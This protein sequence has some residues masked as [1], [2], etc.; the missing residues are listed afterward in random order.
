MGG[1]VAAH[2]GEVRLRDG[3][4]LA[5]VQF[6]PAQGVPFL[7]CHGFPGSRL[8]ARLCA[9]AASRHGLRL[10]AVDRPGF[11]G[12]DFQPRRR[13]LDW[14]SDV[15]ELMEHLAI[16]RFGVVAASGGAPYA[17]ACAHVLR[18]HV[19][20]VG[21][22]CGVGPGAPAHDR[23]V[24]SV[25]RLLLALVRRV[26]VAARVVCAATGAAVRHTPGLV[27]R[28]LGASHPDTRILAH[29]RVRE[30]LVASMRE[31]FRAGSRGVAR[32]L[33]LLTRP[34]GFD[35]HDVSAEVHLWHGEL[36]RVVPAASTRRLERLLPRCT[37]RYYPDDG[38][39]SVVFNHLDDIL[40]EMAERAVAEA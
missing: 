8:E 38:H 33:L 6:G 19:T 30:A 37:A 29:H 16:A 13:I 4:V 15:L 14:P 40:A 18:E 11:G 12:S 3:R 36:D 39:Y 32:D 25:E 7:Y 23:R 1:T 35:Q 24:P 17:L 9:A 28:V 20:R 5:Y 10:V 34:W 2:E 26:P 22:V 21:I 27:L 31:A